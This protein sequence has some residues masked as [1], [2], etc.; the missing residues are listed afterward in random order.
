MKEAFRFLTHDDLRLL[1]EH[2]TASHY[3]QNEVILEEGSHRQAIF[4]IRSGAARVV[5]G[6]LGQEI[7]VADMGPGEMFGEMSFLEGRGASAAVIADEASQID[8]IEGVYVQSLLAS[9]PGFSSRFYQ[10]LATMLS[11]RLRERTQL[12]IPQEYCG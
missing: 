6:H 5:H 8:V 1:I 9:V 7:R 3:H 11:A 4:F 10:S 2:I 12:P